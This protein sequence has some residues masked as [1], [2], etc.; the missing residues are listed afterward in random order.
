MHISGRLLL[1][2]AVC[3]VTG[4]A[5]VV[6]AFERPARVIVRAAGEDPAAPPAQSTQPAPAAPAQPF[7]TVR[8]SE[9]HTRLTLLSLRRTGLKVVTAQLEVSLDRWS[10]GSW[11]PELEGEEGTWHTAEGLRLVDE[12]N[13]RE[14]LPLRD[15]DGTCLCSSDIERLDPG[16]SAVIAAKF[17]APPSAVT[18]A[19]VHAPGFPSFDAVP[20]GEAT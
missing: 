15:P 11:L 13:G 16:E 4:V 2:L 8:G 10:D 14:H 6:L 3:L 1:L 17:P 9:A 18:Q 19:S 5:A 20:L 12:T 7:G